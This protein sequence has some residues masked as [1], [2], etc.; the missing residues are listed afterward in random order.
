MQHISGL[1]FLIALAA[2]LGAQGIRKERFITV[3]SLVINAST[4]IF[5]HAQQHEKH[6]PGQCFPKTL[7][8][9]E[10]F[11]LSTGTMLD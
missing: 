6:G 3:L 9:Y 2:L 4:T 10:I 8:Y 7:A 5:Y 1:E 11:P